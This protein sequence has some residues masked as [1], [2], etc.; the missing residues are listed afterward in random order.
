ME[1]VCSFFR[2]VI[3][4][5]GGWS[6]GRLIGRSVGQEFFNFNILAAAARQDESAE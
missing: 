1:L 3:G 4:W 6:V 2:S 5:L